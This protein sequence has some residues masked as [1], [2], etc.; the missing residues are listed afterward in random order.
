ME[1]CLM[2]APF[3]VASM[4]LRTRTAKSAIPITDCETRIMGVPLY[5]KLW[6]FVQ[7]NYLYCTAHCIDRR[8]EIRYSWTLNMIQSNQFGWS[9]LEGFTKTSQTDPCCSI[10]EW[11]LGRRK[12]R[13]ILP[14]PLTTSQWSMML[15]Q[16]KFYSVKT[17]TDHPILPK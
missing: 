12:N 8:T 16:N 14:N 7:E 13:R 15:T 9:R 17:I 5:S 6:K 3:K 1:T 10:Q 2:Q 11:Q 4:K